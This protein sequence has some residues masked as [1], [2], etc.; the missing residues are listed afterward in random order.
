MN[1]RTTEKWVIR[2]SGYSLCNIEPVMRWNK[3]WKSQMRTKLW[4][5][6]IS[7]NQKWNMI[8][9]WERQSRPS[10]LRVETPMGVEGM[11]LGWYSTG[12]PPPL[13]CICFLSTGVSIYSHHFHPQLTLWKSCVYFSAYTDTVSSRHP[14]WCGNMDYFPTS[15][16][17]V[18]FPDFI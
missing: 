9:G 1:H 13:D 12:R 16:C 4:M 2:Y 6:I 8:E 14:Q 10:R 18:N 7:D 5:R 15:Y 3:K 11:Y 17:F